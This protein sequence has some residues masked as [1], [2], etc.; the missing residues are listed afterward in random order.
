MIKTHYLNYGLSPRDFQMIL[1]LK[2]LIK[3][4]LKEISIIW[5]L[6]INAF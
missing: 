2:Q 6:M 4:F 5:H 1:L 3:I